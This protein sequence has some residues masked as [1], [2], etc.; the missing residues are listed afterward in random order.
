MVKESM[1]E[2]PLA[3]VG[4]TTRGGSHD[5][6]VEVVLVSFDEPSNMAKVAQPSRAEGS[7]SLV[8]VGRDPY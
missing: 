5:T 7:T 4:A 3:Q 1:P 2:D 6:E 8:Q